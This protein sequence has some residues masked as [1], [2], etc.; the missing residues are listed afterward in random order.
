MDGKAMSNQRVLLSPMEQQELVRELAQQVLEVTAPKELVLFDETAEEYFS[1]PDGI[2][3]AKGKDEL[4]GSGV[5]LTLLT[6]YILAVVTP[7]I[8]LLAG[9]VGE[10]VKAEGQAGV[11]RFVRRLFRRPQPEPTT[12]SE[13]Q[14]ASLT[15]QQLALVRDVALKRGR[16]VGLPDDRATLLADAIAG[17]VAVAG[18]S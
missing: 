4:V 3:N 12:D 6:P 2:L 17:G 14:M 15:P 1:D 8:Q 9:M 5:E 16:A 11:S 10:S 7:V 18:T 13:D